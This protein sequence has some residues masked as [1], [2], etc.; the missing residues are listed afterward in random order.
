MHLPI[1][2]LIKL[3]IHNLTIKLV[4]LESSYRGLVAHGMQGFDYEKSKNK[5]GNSTRFDV[6]AMIAIG[7]K[8]PKETLPPNLQQ[9]ENPNDRKQLNE[10]IMEGKKDVSDNMSNSNI[11][12][13][14]INC[15]KPSDPR[16]EHNYPPYYVKN[17]PKSKTLN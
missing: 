14:C 8:G 10:I 2:L 16:I 6:M 17:I 11:N 5:F 12:N 15:T 7:K 1:F 9:K 4:L 13:I 3:F